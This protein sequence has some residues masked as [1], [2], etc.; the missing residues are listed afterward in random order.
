[1]CRR[2]GKKNTALTSHTPNTCDFVT[3]TFLEMSSS[4][5]DRNT[6]RPPVVQQRSISIPSPA[7]P[8]PRPIYLRVIPTSLPRI[9]MGFLPVLL[10]TSGFG[11]ATA[12]FAYFGMTAD[13]TDVATRALT[14]ATASI[15]AIAG[16]F[17]RDIVLIV[18]SVLFTHL[19]LEIFIVQRAIEYARNESDDGSM[20]MAYIG[21]A[22][23]IVHLLPF[24]V[25]D[26]A[27]LRSILAFAGVIVNN[28][29]ILLALSPVATI[30]LL[31]VGITSTALLVVSRNVVTPTSLWCVLQKN[32]FIGMQ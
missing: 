2:I 12:C 18:N 25:L 3:H 11:A 30:L 32:G 4:L 21:A 7:P 20:V 19:G 8:P 1:M 24:F 9:P 16:F 27:M 14:I 29:L 13:Y 31:P 26:N 28:L 10:L 6:Q 17:A 5:G 23:V 15:A 22:T